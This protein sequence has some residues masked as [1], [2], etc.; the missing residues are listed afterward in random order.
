LRV[1]FEMSSGKRSPADF[2]FKEVCLEGEA[3]IAYEADL[4]TETLQQ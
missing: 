4:W 2:Q 3:R 1:Y